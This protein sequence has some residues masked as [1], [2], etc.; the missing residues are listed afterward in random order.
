MEVFSTPGRT[1]VGGNH[2]DHNAGRVLAAAVDLDIVAVV[3]PNDDGVIRVRSEDYPPVE[4]SVDQLDVNESEQFSPT[5]LVRGVCT[6]LSKWGFSLGG[7]DAVTH[8]SVPEGSGLSSSAAFEVMTTKILSKLY[9]NDVVDPVTNAQISQFSENEYFGKPCGLMDQTTCAVGGLVTIDFE[10]FANPIVKKVGFDFLGSGYAAV[11]VNTGG[12]HADLHH[13]Y[14]ALENEMKAVAKSLGGSVLREFSREELLKKLPEVRSS[15]T[16]RAILRALHFYD[17]D[18][19]V[20]DQVEALEAGRFD[21][22]LNMVTAS[23]N[24]SWT[25]LQNCYSSSRVDE[26]GISVALAITARLL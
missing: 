8:S 25:L 1:E 17:D 21:D 22:F 20:V 19:R 11:I 18:L 2:T 4:V 10:D 9:N 12:S 23:G 16:D 24:S 13:D 26:Q 6:G 3:A 15:V 7:F 5:S 14:I